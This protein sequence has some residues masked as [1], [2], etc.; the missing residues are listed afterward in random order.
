MDELALLKDFRL[1]DASPDGAREHA[2]QALRA[3]M[4]RRRVRRRYVFALVFAGAALLVAG[5][6]AIA[7][8]FVV[9]APA[10]TS[11]K[12]QFAGIGIFRG[13]LIPL[14]H[15]PLGIIADKARVAA[16][17]QSSV[18]PVYLFVAPTKSR[19]TC[20]FVWIASMR[21][22]DGRPNMSGG[23]GSRDRF[24]VGFS[25]TNV[26]GQ[27]LR[28][29]VGWVGF[30]ARTVVIG[31]DHGEQR[32]HV[33][34]PWL[35][36]EIRRTPVSVIA[37]D[38]SGRVVGRNPKPSPVTRKPEEPLGA[39]HPVI[40]VQ[41][42]Y[43]HR[44]M[45]ISVAR[46]SRGGRCVTFELPGGSAGSCGGHPPAPTEIAVY[47]NQIGNAQT[48]GMLVLWGEV[49]SRI[50][51]LELRFEDGRVVRLPLR[52]GLTLYQVAHED[53]RKGRRPEMIIA[54]D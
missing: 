12:H 27:Y 43:T 48:H 24:G 44:P 40:T 33:K 25:L 41:T 49:G 28:L 3:A 35:L 47:P 11:V 20:Q 6:Y 53:Y 26:H 31:Y 54:R 42:R 13:E 45:T 18:G 51:R 46:G 14:P 2:R 15:Q 16:V 7:R 37:Y 9:G 10:P 29:A 38:V 1:Q 52:E 34:P 50:E 8:E 17:L 22:P 19:G 39:D 32:I 21:M 4:A 30:S 36:A 23:C 5:A